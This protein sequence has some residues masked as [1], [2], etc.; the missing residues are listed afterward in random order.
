MKK[1]PT[2]RHDVFDLYW[3]FAAERQAIFERRMAEL[4]SPWTKDPIL[5]SYK[6]CNVYR[7]SDRISQYLIK[8]VIYN[9][10]GANPDDRL[11][12]IIA[13]RTFSESSTWE[14]FKNFLGQNPTLDDLKRGSFVQAVEHAKKTNGKL[15]TN[16]FILCANNAY[17]HCSKHL[18]HIELFKHMFL[19]DSLAEKLLK[20]RSLQ[21]IYHLLHKYPLMGDFMSYQITVDINYSNLINFSENSFV[22][23]GPGSLRGIKKAFVELGEYSP[24][25]VITWTVENQKV[26]MERRGLEFHGLFGRPLHAIDCQGLF[27]ELDKYCRVKLPDLTSTRTRIKTKFSPQKTKIQYFFP[28]KWELNSQI[29]KRTQRL[30]SDNK[31]TK[32]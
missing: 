15:Y 27:C 23:T 21:E 9:Q 3:Y 25:E 29:E 1:F 20:A 12:Q 31:I 24:E 7:A 22:K 19:K 5:Q 30:F 28:P 14:Q 16:A 18:N 6:F 17:G 13:F 2:P 10:S 32:H 26:E 4:P 11:F 8:D